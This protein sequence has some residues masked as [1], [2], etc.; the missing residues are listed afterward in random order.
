MPWLVA[1]HQNGTKCTNDKAAQ[2]LLQIY[3]TMTRST[4]LLCLALR[5]GSLGA[6][7]AYKSNQEKL[8]ALGW[9]IE[10]LSPTAAAGGD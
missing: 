2:R 1:K 7:G 4:H 6:G 9:R 10:H 3:V 5:S 8:I